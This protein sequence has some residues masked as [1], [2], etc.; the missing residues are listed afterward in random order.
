[1]DGWMDGWMDRPRNGTNELS[2]PEAD[3]SLIFWSYVSRI[4]CDENMS[5]YTDVLVRV[6]TFHVM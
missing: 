1:M 2:R 5:V 4:V 3:C 6:S